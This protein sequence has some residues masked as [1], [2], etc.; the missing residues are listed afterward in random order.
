MVKGV[1]L[2]HLYHSEGMSRL[3]KL[4][5]EAERGGLIMQRRTSQ[6]QLRYT[7]CYNPSCMKGPADKSGN[8]TRTIIDIGS[9]R[10]AGYRSRTNPETGQMESAYACSAACFLYIGSHF[11]HFSPGPRDIS[12]T[13]AEPEAVINEAAR[14]IV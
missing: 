13:P 1:R 9:G 8:P 2:G 5:A 7:E 10:F 6:D 14:N 11:T 4:R 12:Q 3:T